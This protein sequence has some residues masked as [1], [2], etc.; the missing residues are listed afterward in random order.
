[1]AL[2]LSLSVNLYTTLWSGLFGQALLGSGER[3]ERGEH[4]FTEE[5]LL[6][7]LHMCHLITPAFC[8]NSGV[9]FV[10]VCVLIR[11]STHVGACLPK[12]INHF[13]SKWKAAFCNNFAFF[14]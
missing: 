3:G 4:F 6:L 10:S 14:L 9:C 13:L 8:S 1:M 2:C 7:C 5:P 12:Y 11:I